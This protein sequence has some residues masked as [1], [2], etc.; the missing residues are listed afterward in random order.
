[1]CLGELGFCCWHDCFGCCFVGCCFFCWV[2]VFGEGWEEEGEEL[3]KEE[4]EKEVSNFIKNN[5][6]CFL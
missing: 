6:L 4:L 2:E 5:R 3:E 1:M